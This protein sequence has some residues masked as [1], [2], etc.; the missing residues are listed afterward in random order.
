FLFQIES[1]NLYFHD[2][3]S[4]YDQK[5]YEELWGQEDVNLAGVSLAYKFNFM[6]GSLSLGA[7]YGYG[8][9][10]DDRTGLERDI[11]VDKTMG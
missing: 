1:E 7:S 2:Y 6:L 4:K 10:K 9:I 3:L 5:T 8:E 11:I